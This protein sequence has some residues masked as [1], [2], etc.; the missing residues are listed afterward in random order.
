MQQLTESLFGS[1]AGIFPMSDVDRSVPT[2][3]ESGVARWSDRIAIADETGDVTY[4]ELNRRANQIGRWIRECFPKDT[5]A[6]GLLL[7]HGTPAIIGLLAALK[8]CRIYVPLDPTVSAKINR[9]IVADAEISLILTDNQNVRAA[10]EMASAQLR[11]FNIDTIESE[12]PGEDLGLRI[13]PEAPAAIYYT[14]G[15]TGQPKGVVH[16]H[17][18]LI[19]NARSFT[20]VTGGHMVVV[21]RRGDRQHLA[22]RLDPVRLAVI[23]DE[24]DHGLNRR[25][26]SAWAK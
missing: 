2:C 22:D 10:T 7:E 9:P 25:S 23:V 5:G 18:F 17:A 1:D 8:S 24:R 21:G 13:G 11:V 12:M 19:H 3:F 4:Q 16:M 15:S 14:S 26:S 6:I 20:N